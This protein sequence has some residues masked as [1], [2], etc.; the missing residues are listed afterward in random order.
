MENTI[1]TRESGSS[2]GPRKSGWFGAKTWFGLAATA[3]GT[4][5]VFVWNPQLSATGTDRP[6]PA[7][8][9]LPSVSVSQPLQ[10]DVDARLQ[11][12]GQFA[13]V[14]QLEIR[15]QVGG[16]LT[17]IAFRDGDIVKKGDLLFVIDPEPYE[18]RLSQAKAQL[19]SA[20][21]RVALATSEM[22]RAETSIRAG[23]ESRQTYDQRVAER[24]TAL[25]AV[26][27]AE[28]MIRDAR[29]DLD[30]TRIT[31]PFTGRI[32]THLV[33]IGNLVAGSRAA[34]SPTTLLA[35]MVSL[36]PIFLNFDMSEADHMAFLRARGTQ[37]SPLA[38]P[39]DLAL[40]DEAAFTRRGTLDFVDNALNRSSGTIRARATVPNPDL[41]LTPGAFARVRLPL[42]A[43]AP[44]LLVPDASVLPDQSEHVVM[45]VGS[46]GT[47]APKIVKV[48]DLRGGLRVVRSGL[49]PTDR[50]VIDGI[51][52][53]RPGAK[54]S[55]A[56][57][58]IKFNPERE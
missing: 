40:S 13:G 10:K 38:Y 53:A 6:A 47:V 2:G 51:P 58:S 27:A 41:L 14:E 25:A 9:P 5:A 29:F 28:A 12:L 37:Q 23:V 18:I 11:F 46:D 31:A 26:D 54:V 19:E 45:T 49:A 35:T 7:P 42:S 30:R 16:T 22:E 8:A 1:N 56:A 32:G 43:P 34:G 44:A 15:A 57:G 20:K 3:A 24:R 36:D 55:P 52:S 21:A 33:S 48:G 39:V 50:V 17:Q 4:A